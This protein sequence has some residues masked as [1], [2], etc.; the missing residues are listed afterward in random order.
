M[1]TPPKSSAPRAKPKPRTA[2]TVSQ[3][4][5]GPLAPGD[6]YEAGLSVYVKQQGLEAWVKAGVISKVRDG[7]TADEA[8]SRVDDFV[9]DSVMRQIADLTDD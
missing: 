9:S 6:T 3:L 7:E 5:A 1:P 8:R 4:D 2:R